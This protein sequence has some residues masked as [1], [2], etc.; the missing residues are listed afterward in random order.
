MK[1][2]ILKDISPQ[3]IK[4]N[5][6]EDVFAEY[7]PD[8]WE[9]NDCELGITKEAVSKNNTI[10]APIHN[11]P[12]KEQIKIIK[13]ARKPPPSSPTSINIPQKTNDND[14]SEQEM[15]QRFKK[16]Q[17]Q[18]EEARKRILGHPK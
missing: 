9:D 12:K 3:K 4:S 6:T 10:D 11:E 14:G 5:K 17:R 7:I 18:Y 2:N 8:S 16:K 15:E 13:L 1:D